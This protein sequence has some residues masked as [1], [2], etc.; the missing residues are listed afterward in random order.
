MNL[1]RDEAIAYARAIT[2]NRHF[3]CYYG[4]Y[5]VRDDVTDRNGRY[6]RYG[7]PGI[8]LN[9]CIFPEIPGLGYPNRTP[10]R[11]P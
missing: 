9:I 1:P 2:E 7:Y 3:T 11:R 6:G 8:D 4:Q 5:E 10:R